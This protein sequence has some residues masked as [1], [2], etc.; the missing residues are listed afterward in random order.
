MFPHYEIYI[1]S[2][3]GPKKDRRDR[4][5]VY[6]VLTALHSAFFPKV[7]QLR[8]HHSKQLDPATR[9]EMDGR[10]SITKA[11]TPT[12]TTFQFINMYQFTAAN[13][14]GQTEMWTATE[15]WIN[16]RKTAELYFREIWIVY[17]WGAAGT[18]LN[19]SLKI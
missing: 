3:Q 8:C 14:M 17:I 15:N 2:T 9:R 4:P 11:Q 19:L 6:S 5:Y 16:N 10:L 7:T 1:T 13:P 18:M 12:G